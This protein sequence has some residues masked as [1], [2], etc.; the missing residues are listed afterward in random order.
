M[1]TIFPG[2]FDF[3]AHPLLSGKIT[4]GLDLQTLSDNYMHRRYV[5]KGVGIPF[6]Y[7]NWTLFIDIRCSE[8]FS[9]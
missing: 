3:E 1:T 6:R 7:S 4:F 8:H 5:S 9:K 2:F